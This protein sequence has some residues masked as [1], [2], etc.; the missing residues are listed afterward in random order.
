[1]TALKIMD[2]LLE[3]LNQYVVIGKNITPI[4]HPIKMIRTNQEIQKQSQNHNHLRQGVGQSSKP[5]PK[6]TKGIAQNILKQ[7]INITGEATKQ[8]STIQE[9]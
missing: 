1:M 8:I 7:S 5:N 4:H 2:H 9:E 3:T 6:D